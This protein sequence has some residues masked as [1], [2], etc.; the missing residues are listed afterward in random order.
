MGVGTRARDILSFGPFA[1]AAGERLL[2]R[3]GAP[4]DL[5]ARTLDT[6]I[7]LASRPNQVV[8]KREL[9]ALVWPDVTVEE[10]SLRF[11]IAALRRTL[12]D[13]RD[14][15]RYIATLAGRGYCFVAPV[16]RS[17]TEAA[18]PPPASA[19]A[20]APMPTFL[21]A[22]LAR[23]V[24]RSDGVRML[25]AQLASARFVTIV[26]AGGVGKTTVAVAVAHDLL[27]GFGGAV[28]F[29]DL[30]MLT[31]PD[32]VPASLASML[33]VSIQ[34]DD[35][36]PGLLAHIGDRRML[37]VLDN[38]EH[39]IDAAARLAGTI[40]TAAPR[41][42]IL[43]TSREA[44]RIEGE[45]VHR[46][47]PLASPPDAP[48][49]TAPE[50]LTYPAVQLFVERAAARGARLDLTDADA[51][52]VAHICRSLD[53]VALAIEL[54]A[55]RVEAYGLR[56]TA[57][58]LDQHLTL[59]WLGQRSAPPRQR[60]LQATLDWSYGLLSESERVVFHRLAV[61]VGQFTLEAALAVV[62]SAE[63][64]REQVF[65]A[66]DSL[67]AKSLVAAG[68]ARAAMRYRL[69]DTTRA[70]ARA[71][72]VADT[73]RAALAA[74]HAAYYRGWLEQTGP[75]WSGVTTA[76]ERAPYLAGMGNVRAALEWCFG[77]GGDAEMGVGLAAAAAPVLLVMSLLTECHRW[78][79]RALRA[80]GPAHAAE[81]AEM[82]LRGSLGLSLMFTR[83]N[84][85]DVR[86]ALAR[87]LDLAERRGDLPYQLQLLGALHLFH[88]RI[89]AF[90]PSLAFAE[91]SAAAAE[92]LGDSVAR[93]AAE[94]WL[95]ISHHLMGHLDAAQTHLEAALASPRLSRR[96]NTIE[97]GFDYHNRARITLARNL[98]L[99]GFP[100]RAAR[101]AEET[102]AEAAALDHPVT[103]CMALIWAVTVFAWRRDWDRVEEHIDR[104]I[105][106]ADR[107]A[108]VPYQAAGL[109][110]KGELS[111]RRGDV[112]AGIA[113][114]RRGLDALHADR[115]E[116]LTTELIATLAEGLALT[117][118][119]EDAL[120]TVARAIAQA[121]Q[122]GRLFTLPELLRIQAAILAAQPRPDPSAA[123]ACLNR[124]LDLGRQQ[125]ALGWQ[126]RTAI[127]LAALWARSDRAA[128]AQA[129]L[130]P[131][132]ARFTEG[133]DTPDLQAAQR[134]LASL[135]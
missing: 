96:F 38:C 87:A 49:L 41:A 133:A 7:A 18:G 111:I 79:E 14:G 127:D 70:Y 33:G 56:Q 46:L 9:M 116:L 69:L 54:A 42:H 82:R 104:F 74:R 26:G 11:H 43:A 130:R 107:Y 15:A 17:G 89:G 83:G 88:E 20:D 66:I 3:D 98:W 10:G 110:V 72:A 50:A 47:T 132:V 122:H 57:E 32:M 22:R 119:F 131:I 121:E 5:G 65:A 19:A 67:V 99:L 125:G 60:T 52:T 73:E 29:V 120:A 61:F 68:P 45:Q 117:G 25:S 91:R 27:E 16:A 124:S 115:Y 101:V 76:A 35:P 4:V 13:G 64:P 1:L 59:P 30:G 8:G 63:V 90:A 135:P 2:T 37:V 71:I 97:I 51:E 129:L 134:L 77:A 36:L 84:S 62:T 103:L 102:V 58:L 80:L 93:A 126:L 53:G 94:S 100:D 21:P 106:Q 112:A 128:D 113:A 55:G 44:L 81:T 23:M 118:Q 12:G 109:G 95:G 85:E 105:A 92:A 123:E 28:V 48:G 31:D 86:A 39:V 75:G 78:S 6:L 34:S 40:F 114:L 108:M 24:G